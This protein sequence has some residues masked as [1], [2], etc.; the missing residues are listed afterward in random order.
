MDAA[1]Q[2]EMREV[3][4]RSLLA[5][6]PGGWQ[7]IRLTFLCTVMVSS[8][9]LECTGED[10]IVTQLDTPDVA[11]DMFDELRSSMYQPDKGCWFTAKYII[12][13]TGEYRVD[14]DYDNEPEFVPGITAGSYAADLEYFPRA[15]E[16]IPAWLREKLQEAAEESAEN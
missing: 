1:E 12:D 15:E 9:R 13:N 7:Q 10:G 4:G 2:V 16:R 8:A 11:I 14:F 6:A 3:I 5:V